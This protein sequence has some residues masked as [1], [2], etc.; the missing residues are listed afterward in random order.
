MTLGWLIFVL[1][2]VTSTTSST[3]KVRLAGN[4]SLPYA[5][6]LEIYYNNTW[7]TAS[8]FGFDDREARVACY[9]LGF[10]RYGLTTYLAWV[11]YG[12][13]SGPVWLDWPSCTGNELSLAECRGM[14]LSKFQDHIFDQ[15]IM[16]DN[17][18]CSTS[19]PGCD[20]V[21]NTNVQNLYPQ[22]LNGSLDRYELQSF[23]SSWNKCSKH[24]ANE[25]CTFRDLSVKVLALQ[26][27]SWRQFRHHGSVEQQEYS[28]A[29]DAMHHLCNI[30][31]PLD[32]VY[33]PCY[34]SD[35][36]NA[37]H[38]GCHYHSVE[39]YETYEL[40]RSC[41]WLQ[42]VKYCYARKIQ[43]NCN[44]PAADV[45]MLKMIL[46]GINFRPMSHWTRTSY[47]PLDFNLLIGNSADLSEI[48]CSMPKLMVRLAGN[49]SVPNSGRLEVFYNNT[50]GTVCD[51]WF[52]D[53]DAQV[54][55]YMLG[56]G[57]C[58]QVIRQK[59]GNGSG[60]IWLSGMYCTGNELSLAEC[61]HK[62]LGIHSHCRYGHKSDVSIACY[63]NCSTNP[64]D[65]EMACNNGL[66]TVTS[67]AISVVR[68][69]PLYGPVAGGTRVIITGQFQGV[70]TVTAV[71]FGQYRGFIDR[72]RIE[73]NTVF[74]ITPPVNETA[75]HLEIEL[76][77]EDGSLINTNHMFEY[78]GNPV[79]T[80][81]R[82]RNHLTR[83]GT[84][85]TVSGDNLDSVSEPRITL[86]A[87]I[88]RFY[89]DTSSV[90]SKT[91]VDS[92]LCKLPEAQ[93]N[94]SQVMCQLPALTLPDKLLKQ[95][96]KFESQKGDTTEGPGVAAYVSS[97]GRIRADIYVGLKLDGI[98]RFQNI[99]SVDPSIKIQFFPPPVVYCPHLIEFDPNKQ[100]VISIHGRH[101]RR[102]S[103][104]VDFDVRLGVSACVTESLTDKRV[105]CRPPTKKPD[106][107]SN[108]TLCHGDTLSMQVMI[109]FAYYQCS[110]VRYLPQDNTALIVGLSVG[111]AVLFIIVVIVIIIVLLYRK[112]QKGKEA[113][114]ENERDTYE[115]PQD[116]SRLPSDYEVI[117]LHNTNPVYENLT[118]I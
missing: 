84:Q 106:R 21:W 65:H 72:E 89:N 46:Y 99:S 90:S 51:Y 58:G 75:Q 100:E 28:Q 40:F 91:E 49:N 94:G 33:R 6:R 8:T 82:P 29:T 63:D 115:V 52:G 37:L 81:I 44:A 108:D 87:V 27:Y 112:H 14:G 78:R 48:I 32:E 56:F 105:D 35:L 42:S 23:C 97:D 76:V 50:W 19:H 101:L 62:G 30:I 26:H 53:R 113:S 54:A 3:V 107:N 12:T 111:L 85:V 104:L 38:D 77:M 60:P 4:N 5:G 11:L 69:W 16:C 9:M 64:L 68:V 7:G 114:R 41:N 34:E 39:T 61:G 2:C 55:C 43:E 47:C 92:E 36:Y 109:G 117:H 86:T 93:E 102:G 31:E 25:G 110:C 15:S 83:G 22:L 13:G 74:A 116:T 103:R 98:R 88:T 70:S 66:T 95:L 10:G 1:L 57:R 118:H 80:D 71:Y 45:N 79:F 67:Q 96:E 59:F 17:S 73:V 18:S 24:L 20:V